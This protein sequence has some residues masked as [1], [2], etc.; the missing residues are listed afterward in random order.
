MAG[1]DAQRQRQRQRA[2][3]TRTP[4]RLITALTWAAVRCHV[5]VTGAV[6]IV[7][8][9]ADAAVLVI[10]TR[11]WPVVWQPQL[12]V[13]LT[14]TEEAG[15]ASRKDTRL[16]I[17]PA[18]AHLHNPLFLLWEKEREDAETGSASEVATHLPLVSDRGK[19]ISTVG[20]SFFFDNRGEIKISLT[21]QRYIQSL[22]FDTRLQ[23][24]REKY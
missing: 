11:V 2:A 3:F 16:S 19:C 9:A 13:R 5:A 17:R 10:G 8:A 12:V 6:A 15:S 18:P 4:R 1:R 21:C 7:A 22:P 20:L 14:H 24:D 23:R